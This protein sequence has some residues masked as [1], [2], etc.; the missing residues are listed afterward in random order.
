MT[1]LSSLK[2][3]ALALLA[4]ISLNSA[5]TA[6]AMAEGAYGPDTCKNGYVWREALADDTICVT[7]AE[8]TKARKQNAKANL[9]R[10]PGGGA[11][12]PDTCRNGYVWRDAA[13]DDHVCVTPAERDQA[14]AQNAA[15]P[16]LYENAD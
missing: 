15:A 1:T 3:G 5:F 13:E 4:G 6:S 10:N 12:G 2:F 14:A 7:P 16:D 11:Y 8:R 9:R